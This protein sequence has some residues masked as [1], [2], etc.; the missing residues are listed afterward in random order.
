M[1]AAND[2]FGRDVGVSIALHVGVVLLIFFQAVLRPSETIDVRNAIRVDMVALPKKMEA[3]PEPAPQ[4]EAPPAKPKEIAPKKEEPKAKAV[5]PPKPEN[6]APKVNLA[7]KEQSAINKLKELEAMEKLKQMEKAEKAKAAKAKAEPVA[8]N[9]ISQGDALAGLSRIDYD[10]Y[11]GEIK[12]KVH[13]QS[14]L[15]QWLSDQGLTAKVRVLIDEHGNILKRQ[16]I[17]S[18]GNEVFDAK[19]VEAID[20][21]APFTPP[22]ARLRGLLATSGIVFNFPK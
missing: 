16:V 12:Q 11:F 9:I 3:L 2:H 13:A 14:S 4:A 21:S 7:K 8:G 20:S 22:P 17:A 6:N 18:S 5:T 1:T 10:R 19:A 15:P